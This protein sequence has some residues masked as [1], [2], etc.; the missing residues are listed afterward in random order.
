MAWRS[1]KGKW[2]GIW[3]LPEDDF[4]AFYDPSKIKFQL[5][6]IMTMTNKRDSGISIRKF[7]WIEF[8][9]ILLLSHIIFSQIILQGTVTDNGGEYL[10]S[11]AEPVVGAL[12]Q[13]T[14]QTDLSRVFSSF[15]DQ[16]GQYSIQIIPTGI[17]DNILKFPNDFKLLQN[18]PN[19]FNP[20][21]V[22]AYELGKPFYVKIEIYN[23]LGQRV[24]TLFDG[25]VSSSGQFVWNATND[26]G[27]GVPAGVYIY[28]MQADG[29]KINRKML[30]LNEWHSENHAAP[31]NQSIA[32]ISGGHVLSKQ[33]SNQYKLEITGE[34]IVP[35]IQSDITI[36]ANMTIDFSVK[37]TLTDIDGNV[38]KLV[39]IGNQWWM[40]ENLKVTR[41]RN[42]D[43]IPPVTDNSTWANLK[44]GAY[45]SYND[46][47]ANVSI[48]GRLYNWCAANDDRNIAPQGWHVS[49]D[50]DWQV[51]I[52]FLGGSSNAG[53]KLKETGFAHWQNPNTGATNESGFSGLPGG[54]RH[55][56]GNFFDVGDIAYFWSSTEYDTRSARPGYLAYF[57]ANISRAN[58]EKEYGF[59]VRCVKDVPASPSGGF[60][61]FQTGT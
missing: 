24:K 39:K 36:A 7:F 42:G 54:Y 5:S 45:C 1:E 53:G 38:Y 2:L 50:A 4:L 47:E 46:D 23:V 48:Y 49:S 33:I 20:T 16:E 31:V 61:L 10:G 18:Y 17:A 25:F 58:L 22:I 56:I 6:G 12:V 43:P 41:Y 26:M 35:Y 11:G 32:Q 15:T 40:A 55:V 57:F 8:F 44:T 21:T 13:I 52:D 28:S 59:S 29:M 60:A 3:R 27:Q 14:D 51:L 37:R 30:L 34:N 9:C 19:P